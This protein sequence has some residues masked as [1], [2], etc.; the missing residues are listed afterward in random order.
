MRRPSSMITSIAIITCNILFLL[1]QEVQG[2]SDRR[3]LGNSECCWQSLRM[4]ILSGFVL[5]SVLITENILT[6]KS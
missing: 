1:H 3:I 2:P 4:A 5:I 6:L